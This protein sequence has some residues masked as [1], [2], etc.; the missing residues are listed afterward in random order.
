MN[1]TKP[2]LALALGMTLFGVASNAQAATPPRGAFTYVGNVDDG[3]RSGVVDRRNFISGASST[4]STALD[5]GDD[6]ATGDVLGDAFDEVI[7]GDD[8]KGRIDIHDTAT[9]QSTSFSTAIGQDVFAYDDVGDDITTGDVIAGGKDEIIVGDVDFGLIIVYSSTGEEL[10]RIAQVGFDDD[11]RVVAGDFIPGHALDEIALVNSEDEGRVDVYDTD[12]NLLARQHGGY[13]GDGDDVAA[14]DDTGDLV[15]EVIVANDEGGRIDSH[16]FAA[17]KVHSTD[18]AYDS[19]DKMDVGDVTGDGLADVV[20]ANTEDNRVDVINFFGPG[21]S[22]GSAYDS[23][24]RFSVGVFGSGDTDG[25]SIP[26]RVE[27]HGIRNAQGDLLLNL[28]S[29]GASPCRKDVVVE[30]G[31]MTGR[32]PASGVFANVKSTFDKASEV[33][34]VT[35]C[36][37]EGVSTATGMGLIVDELDHELTFETQLKG[38][39]PISALIENEFELKAPFVRHAVWINDFVTKDGGSP[40]GQAGHGEQDLDFLMALDGDTDTDVHESTFIHELGH[41]LG[42]DH[43]GATNDF[44]NCKP[45]Y[46]SVMNYAMRG[47]VPLSG[48]SGAFKFDFSHQKLDTLN[49]ALLDERKVLGGPASLKTLWTNGKGTIAEGAANLAL[50]WN[51]DGKPDDFSTTEKP[52]QVDLNLNDPLGNP[53]DLCDDPKLSPPGLTKLPGHNDWDA[54][55]TKLAGPGDGTN[56]DESP[57]VE[58]T[59]EEMVLAMENRDDRSFPDVAIDVR[60]P[61]PGFTGGVLGVAMDAEN[62]YA[63]HTYKNALTDALD[64]KSALVVLDRASLASKATIPV[65]L[66]ARAV[67][68]NPLTRRAYVVNRGIGQGSTLSVVNLATRTVIKEIPLGQVGVDVAVNTKLN[69]VYVSNPAAEDIQIVNGATNVLL[70]PVQVGKG[71]GG[72]AVDET[73]GIVYVAMT[74]RSSAPNFTALGRMR[75]TGAT[76]TVLGQID[77]GDPLV[78]A[79]DVAIDP[80]RDRVYVAGL[81]GGGVHPSVTVLTLGGQQL[82]RIPVP[83]PSRAISVNPQAGRVFS[84][85]DRGVEVINEDTLTVVRHIDAALPFSV[86]TENGP[87]R[88]LYVGDV[89]DGKLRRLSYTSGEPR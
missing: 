75:D 65:G 88:Q 66:D 57:L 86:V 40:S 61:K 81:G 56:A 80:Q 15:D 19:D 27:L 23:D 26:D 3:A 41:S 33:K 49:E 31:H 9:K 13:D 29:R 84:V 68:I 55:N 71:L 64:G 4:F 69:R 58:P 5:D 89:R 12:R 82:T 38:T 42:L 1:I 30:S 79:T 25:D 47:G 39:A 85:G 11:D 59:T 72:L 20:V 2:V 7:V 77:L 10:K 70:P 22:F 74:H 43:G 54:L 37:Y 83:G 21:G 24:D 63:L 14:G 51:G 32:E 76:Q 73:S 36:P 16:D 60:P 17:G 45:N 53:G 44:V 67:A 78:Q 34:P 28:K 6:M 52:L 48:S 87:A 50:D 18:S 8:G 46:L 35:P 62:V